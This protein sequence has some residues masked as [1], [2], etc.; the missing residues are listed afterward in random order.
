MCTIYQFYLYYIYLYYNQD[1]LKQYWNDPGL[2]DGEKFLRDFILKQKYLDKDV[3][4]FVLIICVYVCLE[5]R[6]KCRK[7]SEDK[8]F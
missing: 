4:R 3:D 5:G 2:D 1:S 8:Y 7:K 6:F